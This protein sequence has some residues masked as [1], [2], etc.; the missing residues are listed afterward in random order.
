[1]PPSELL[2]VNEARFA[3]AWSIQEEGSELISMMRRVGGVM[4]LPMG[5]AA[6]CQSEHLMICGALFMHIA[7][8]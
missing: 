7:F 4:I 1:M 3:N 2:S 8:D 6:V 5:I